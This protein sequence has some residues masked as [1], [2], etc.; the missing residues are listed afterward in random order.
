MIDQLPTLILSTASVLVLIVE[1][2]LVI[3]YIQWNMLMW[4]LE[5]EDT[6]IIH[7]LTK[8]A[9]ENQDTFSWSQGVHI[10]QVTLILN[11]IWAQPYK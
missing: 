10:T 7:T 8:G 5:N 4:T 9:L 11:L 3:Q 6:C 1:F 2:S